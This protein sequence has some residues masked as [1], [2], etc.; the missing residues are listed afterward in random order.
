MTD[1]RTWLESQADRQDPV[2]HLARDV[3]ADWCMT[4]RTVGGVRRHL[5]GRHGVPRDFMATVA[6][7]AIEYQL[8]DADDVSGAV[9]AVIRHRDEDDA[10]VEL[11]RAA[12]EAAGHELEAIAL[13][14]MLSDRAA[15]AADCRVTGDCPACGRPS[16]LVKADDRFYH[17]DGTSNLECWRQI[18]MG[19]AVVQREA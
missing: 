1:F 5:N 7:A 16:R 14:L 2:G 3:A 10:T 6:R 12:A 15:E 11:A 17:S 4:A 8:G 9:G 19:S 13:S 18:V